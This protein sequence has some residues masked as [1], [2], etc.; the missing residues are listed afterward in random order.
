MTKF[1]KRSQKPYFGATLILF[2]PNLGKKHF[3]GKRTQSVFKYSNNLFL[4]KKS[5]K[6]NQPTLRK[7]PK[8]TD[9]QTDIGYFI[10]WGS[11]Y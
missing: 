7:M 2:H 3:P 10:G 9:G 5:E 11:S 6:T 1:F 4:W 8:L